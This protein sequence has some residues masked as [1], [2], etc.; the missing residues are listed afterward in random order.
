MKHCVAVAVLLLFLALA[1]VSNAGAADN[2]TLWPLLYYSPGQT[3]SDL[4]I[5]WPLFD[6]KHRPNEDAW[7]LLFTGHSRKGEETVWDLIWPICRAQYD[8]SETSKWRLFPIFFGHDRRSKH[9]VLFPE[10]WWSSADGGK[11]TDLAMLPWWYLRRSDTHY[12]YGLTPFFIGRNGN[13][14]TYILTP[15]AWQKTGEELDYFHVL[16]IFFSTKKATVFF[17]LYW[18]TA[19]TLLIIPVYGRG[20]AGGKWEAYL[21]PLYV[22]RATNSGC[23]E[24]YLLWPFVAHGR[25]GG[26]VFDRFFPIFNHGREADRRNVDLLWPLFSWDKRGPE[27]QS[28]DVGTWFLFSGS[29][30]KGV[31]DIH[32]LTFFWDI[33]RQQTHSQGFWP[34]YTYKRREKGNV[35]ASFLDPLWFWGEATGEEEHVSA[36]LKIFDYRRQPNGDSRFSFLWRAYR[37]EKSG[38]NVS[39]ESFPFMAWDKSPDR[40]KFSFVWRLFEYE[41]ADGKRS[42]RLF[43]SPKIALGEARQK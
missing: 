28:L 16:P 23:Q 19:K 1:A 14:R 12:F 5:L 29:W 32:V 30:T 37:R 18:N 31:S 2:V 7:R 4:E 20:D 41:K 21:P 9:A 22:H 34:L 43:F 25:G 26:R 13:Q 27:S 33:T 10:F 38:E 40:S 35:N 8:K 24:H 15:V 6:V 11:S 39:W 17:P 36:L 3:E 42:M